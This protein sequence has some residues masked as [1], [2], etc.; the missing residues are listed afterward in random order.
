MKNLGKYGYGEAKDV[1]SENGFCIEHSHNTCCNSTNVEHIRTKA[2]LIRINSRDL[3]PEWADITTKM[4]W[5]LCDGG[6]STGLIQGLC[7][8]QCSL[9]YEACKEDY[10]TG[11][12]RSNELGSG[13]ISFCNK[14]SLICSQLKE[15]YED[16]NGFWTTMGLSV[17]IN[18]DKWYDGVPWTQ[19]FG[20]AKK[21]KSQKQKTKKKSKDKKSE[22]WLDSI[23]GKYEEISAKHPLLFLIVYSSTL[24]T[25]PALISY[26]LYRYVCSRKRHPEFIDEELKEKRR[27]ILEK[28]LKKGAKQ[29]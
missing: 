6:I 15:I 16:S 3:S 21:I 5:S 2:G 8:S 19:K 22:G 28:R 14:N 4:F 27:K 17:N 25:L 26:W 24:I 9:W 20:K 23:S 1:N 18:D 7:P 11:E 13:D 12:K 29:K 10:F